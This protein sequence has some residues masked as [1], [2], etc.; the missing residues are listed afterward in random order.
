MYCTAATGV[1]NHG[2]RPVAPS[3]AENQT[4]PFQA[5]SSAGSLP[6]APGLT[7]ATRLVPVAVPSLTHGS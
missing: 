1:A 6:A 5:T 3:S 4:P 2:S 7:S